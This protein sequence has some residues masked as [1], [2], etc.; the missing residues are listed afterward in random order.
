MLLHTFYTHIHHTIHTETD[1]DPD[2]N[3]WEKPNPDPVS[4]FP[5]NSNPHPNPKNVAG[6]R[7]RAHLWCVVAA[8]TGTR[9]PNCRAF[10][11]HTSFY[12]PHPVY[13]ARE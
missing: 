7:L 1:S 5:K 12:P 13:L 11:C 2:L 6:L 10:Y 3:F 4:V 9:P 8:L